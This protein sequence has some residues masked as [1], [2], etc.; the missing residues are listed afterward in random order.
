MAGS[1]GAFE[2][3]APELL[4]HWQ[5]QVVPVRANPT[6]VNF[7]QRLSMSNAQ[8]HARQLV[9]AMPIRDA[10]PQRVLDDAFVAVPER[11]AAAYPAGDQSDGDLHFSGVIAAHGQSAALGLRW[12]E[13]WPEIGE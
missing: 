13:K 8:P 5:E 11:V 9:R 2:Q 1:Y 12:L 10:M 3:A 6:G 7:D 4:W